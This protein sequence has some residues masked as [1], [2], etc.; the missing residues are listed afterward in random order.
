[1]VSR[2]SVSSSMVRRGSI[3]LGDEA[4]IPIPAASPPL[5][6]NAGFLS[7]QSQYMMAL[8]QQIQQQQQQ[9]M[10]TAAVQ[11]AIQKQQEAPK[12]SA[13]DEK[14]DEVEA[15]GGGA[16]THSP[17]SPSSPSFRWLQ[18]TELWRGGTVR[19][20]DGGDTVTVE[21]S[22]GVVASV[23]MASGSAVAEWGIFVEKIPNRCWIGIVEGPAAGIGARWNVGECPPSDGIGLENTYGTLY[24]GRSRTGC[25]IGRAPRN[26]DLIRFKLDA[27][28]SS[29]FGSL[30]DPKVDQLWYS[31]PFLPKNPLFAIVNSTGRGRFQLRRKGTLSAE[32]GTV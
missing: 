20:E 16:A 9:A 22:V 26:R 1:V 30:N 7:P 11:M 6:P 18:T 4:A 8:Q 23:P 12:Q 2:H 14:A 28:R 27:A 15:K 3:L 19:I 10:I 5:I 17:P 24:R 21:G 25:S 32:K 13:E 29:L 31:G